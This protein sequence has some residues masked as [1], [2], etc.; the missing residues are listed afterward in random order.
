MPSQDIRVLRYA[1]LLHD[2]GQIMIP[3]EILKKPKKLTGEEY[4]IVKRHPLKGVEIIKPMDILKPVIPIILHHH[5]KFD[6]TGYPNGLKGKEIPL[7]SR[8]MA[9]VDA[10]IAMVSKQPYRERISVREALAEIKRYGG[11]Q[12]DPYVVDAFV[13]TVEKMDIP[14][15]LKIK[16][17]F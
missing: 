9:V 7:G 12:F 4:E 13:Q 6:G 17:W 2:A 16:G 11:T 1:S 8:I 14:H 10:F 15:L 5:E 3:D